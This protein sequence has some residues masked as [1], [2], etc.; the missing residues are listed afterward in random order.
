MEGST[1]SMI[2]AAWPPLTA[3]VLAIIYLFSTRN[4]TGYDHAQ[5]SF[6]E[7]VI[8]R[9]DALEAENKVL[10][11]HIHQL[12]TENLSLRLRVKELKTQL[13]ERGC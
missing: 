11:A 9:L 13:E 3:L 1:S 2:S 4:K 8:A 7:A 6:N 10:R 5:A 12:E